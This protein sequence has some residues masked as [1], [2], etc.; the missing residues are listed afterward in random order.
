MSRSSCTTRRLFCHSILPYFA[1]CNDKP[2]ERTN[3]HSVLVWTH[4]DQSVA[5]HTRSQRWGFST[6]KQAAILKY[7]K[8]FPGLGNNL[9][10]HMFHFKESY[11]WNGALVGELEHWGRAPFADA[12]WPRLRNI[13]RKS[14]EIEVDGWE[15]TRS[16]NWM[17]YRPQK[18]KRP[19]HSKEQWRDFAG[20]LG[21]QITW[22]KRGYWL[23]CLLHTNWGHFSQKRNERALQLKKVGRF[24]ALL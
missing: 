18:N 6:N 17:A 15:I 21:Q 16:V 23:W 20:P 24:G 4:L 10:S 12:L 8:W 14:K 3:L 1:R 13:K 9:H 2:T 5:I 11:E 19:V 7:C 22:N